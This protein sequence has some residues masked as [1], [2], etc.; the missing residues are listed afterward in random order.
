M[1]KP[2]V[3]ICCITYN[4][5]KYIRDALEGFVMQETNF[6]FEVLIHDDASTDRTADIIREYEKKYPDIIKPIY[7]K[8]NQYSKGI[9]ISAT[10]N[11]P[12]AQGKYIALC[13]GDDF[14]TDKKKLQIQTDFMEKNND[15]VFCCHGRYNLDYFKKRY[16][17]EPFVNVPEDGIACAHEMA[18]GKFMSYT[19]TFFF[20][21]DIYINIKEKIERDTDN[22][23]MGDLQ[24]VFNFALVGK[25]K[26]FK[27]RM[28]TYRRASGSVT[29]C[30]TGDNLQFLNKCEEATLQMIR[31]CPYPEWLNEREINNVSSYSKKEK[32]KQKLIRLIIGK[33]HFCL[34]KLIASI[35]Y[36]IYMIKH[37]EFLSC[38]KSNK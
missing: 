19:Q 33:I 4:H 27:K 18:L 37:G 1:E 7:Q 17:P 22:A 30:T 28:A 16:Y 11:F 15:F 34:F 23:P 21:N 12:R 38:Y 9:K 20:R 8:E 31:N 29:H 35:R 6:P 10:Y 3:S 26:Y 5:E 13:E 25:I 24:L 2:L 32:V 36:Y 14:W